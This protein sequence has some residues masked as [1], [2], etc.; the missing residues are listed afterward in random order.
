MTDRQTKA[1]AC[2]INPDPNGGYSMAQLA[3]AKEAIAASDAR[4]VPGLVEALKRIAEMDSVDAAIW[5]ASDEARQTL[6][7][8]P[9]E[10]RQ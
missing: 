8:L 3:V 2:A 1:V 6:A 9:E 10:Y 4:L 7:S 5:P